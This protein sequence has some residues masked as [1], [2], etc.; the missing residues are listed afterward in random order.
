MLLGLRAAGEHPDLSAAAAYLTSRNLAGGASL[1][2]PVPLPLMDEVFGLVADLASGGNPTDVD[3]DAA[4]A[5]CSRFAVTISGS[6]KITTPDL[7]G[8]LGS[9]LAGCSLAP[10][11]APGDAG[12]A[13]GVVKVDALVEGGASLEIPVLLLE[14]KVS[15]GSDPWFQNAA[16]YAHYMPRVKDPGRVTFSI[17]SSL[18]A[19]EPR[20][21]A[22]LLNLTPGGTLLLRGATVAFPSVCTELLGAACLATDAASFLRVAR[23]LAALRVGVEGLR[24]RYQRLKLGAGV[25]VPP[26]I[27]GPVDCIR[28]P[29]LAALG[30]RLVEPLQNGR[31]VFAAIHS[32]GGGGA[33]ASSS[34]SSSSSSS[35]SEQPCV[36]KFV[37]GTYGTAAHRHA[38]GA[39]LAP[40]LLC[41]PVTLPGGWF[42]VVMERLDPAKWAEYD[43]GDATHRDA[44]RDAYERA[45]TSGGFVHGDLRACNVLVS[46]LAPRS[47]TEPSAKRAHVLRAVRFL[48]FDWA[49]REGD[50]CYPMLNSALQSLYDAAGASSGGAIKSAHDH[51]MLGLEA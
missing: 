17:N 33:G 9:L 31:L 51:V 45:F 15:K 41:D 13:D 46:Q 1:D 25:A 29:R 7:R 48:D 28:S 12:M 35:S 8:I 24:A 39:G 49:G 26:R 32:T 5:L 30:L 16:Y 44:A 3:R 4:I 21:P 40:R 27:K 14:Y 37:H 42:A 22:L 34:T 6:E 50:V 18:V 23:L 36:V 43:R 2:P 47:D 38:E 19:A 11:A 10:Y 20:L